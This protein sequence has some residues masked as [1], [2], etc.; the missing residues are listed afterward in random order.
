MRTLFEYVYVLSAL[1]IMACMAG[2]SGKSTDRLGT[3]SRL[4]SVRPDS[5]YTI[6]RDIDFNTLDSDSLKA[7]YILTK[8]IA[9]LRVGRSLVTDTLLDDA[10]AY[11]FSVGDTADW[12]VASQ[13]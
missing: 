4:V 3:A 1:A 11:Y 9:N 13:L 2:C 7:R 10:A 12:V 5:A 8:A 6:L